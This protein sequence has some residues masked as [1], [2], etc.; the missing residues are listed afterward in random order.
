M[1]FTRRLA[2]LIVAIVAEVNANTEKV[3]FI[4]PS[5][6]TL[7]DFRPGL[8]DLRLDVL[9]P[10]R[11]RVLETN[12]DRQFPSNTA[13]RGVDSWYL[14]RDLEAGRRYEVRICWPATVRT[15]A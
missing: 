3:I 12:L 7:P 6:I 10:T 15:R 5:P 8:D 1:R 9:S 13:P 14:L 4:A 11:L 2:A